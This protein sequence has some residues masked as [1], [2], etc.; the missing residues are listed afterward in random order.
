MKIGTAIK[1]L[2]VQKGISQTE[3]AKLA[4]INNVS[5][6]II[7]KNSVIPNLVTMNKIAEVLEVNSTLFYFIGL[8]VDDVPKEKQE[9][10]VTF[11]PT[12]LEL[13]KKLL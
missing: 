4:G 3:L 12:I 1:K 8:E 9:I 10:F 6:S 7:E 13:L 2:R 5:L 11:Y